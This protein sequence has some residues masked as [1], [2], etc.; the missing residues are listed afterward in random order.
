MASYTG[1]TDS[2]GYSITL[3]MDEN[4]INTPANTSNI[5]AYA[6]LNSS[7]QY[8]ADWTGSG[9]FTVAGDTKATYSGKYSMPPNPSQ[10]L[11]ASW[12]GDIAH[13]PDGTGSVTL[14]S[15]FTIPSGPSY[16]PLNTTATY[17]FGLTTINRA[18]GSRWTGSAYADCTIN[19]RWTG[20]TW[21]DLTIKKRWSGSAWV[22]LS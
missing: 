9:S 13:N 8:F 3:V 20:S 11:L 15:T 10:I 19:K 21:V 17:T 1:S 12:Q 22:D 16:T 7:Y 5:S 18:A 4:S 14:S 2:R 6:Y